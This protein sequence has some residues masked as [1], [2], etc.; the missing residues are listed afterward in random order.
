MKNK[1]AL[2]V[3][4][5]L[6]Y[7]T[8]CSVNYNINISDNTIT[9]NIDVNDKVEYY[10]KNDPGF[11]IDGELESD[12][13]FL[14]EN[15]PTYETTTYKNDEE[16]GMVL[17]AKH[18][19]VKSFADNLLINDYGIYENVNI[20]EENNILY[21]NLT[22][23]T[24]YTFLDMNNIGY[25]NSTITIKSDYQFDSSNAD[26]I[27]VF[28]N[29]H[30]WYLDPENNRNKDIEFVNNL[31]KK[32]SMFSIAVL[33]YLI[34]QPEVLI[35]I[36]ILTIAAFAIIAGLNVNKKRINNNQL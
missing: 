28:N 12:Q 4:F 30:T 13:A 31:N 26:K 15:Y 11:D 3:L 1:K 36:G 29:E 32:Y 24:G 34:K 9:E 27:D 8:G 17:D 14:K 22:G 25:N 20:Y 23:F 2:L 5:S 7:L 33:L 16:F 10:Y 6:V 18:D 19:S 35:T 21:I